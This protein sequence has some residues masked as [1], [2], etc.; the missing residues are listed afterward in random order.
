MT[1]TVIGAGVF[2]AWCAWFLSERHRVTL[3]DQYGP[4]NA[5]ASSADH[6]RV[7]RCGYGVDEIYSSWARQ[8]LEDWRALETRTGRELVVESGALF[9]G[10]SGNQYIG[11]THTTLDRLGVEVESLDRDTLARRFPQLGLT[12]LGAALFERRAGVIRARAAVHALVDSMIA[13]GRV[14]YRVARAVRPDESRRHEPVLPRSGNALDADVLIFA[15]GPWLASMFPVAVGGR[16]RSTRQEVLHFGVPAG[17]DRFSITQFP[18][19]ID[20]EAGFYGIPD[21]DASG[22]KIGIDRHG[23]VIDPDTYDRL[24]PSE[25]VASTRTWLGQRFPAL[26]DAPLLD[27]HVCQYENTSSGDFLIDRHPAWNHVWIV[28]GGSGHGFKHGPAVGRHVAALV[29]GEAAVTERFKLASKATSAVRAV[30]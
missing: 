1:I 7:I 16:I 19:W 11:D 13:E 29:D 21:F 22:F 18:V 12:A 28:G 27:A 24:V 23:P 9:L 6:S 3:I 2:G 26:A 5:R 30:Y 10:A 14:R 25:L 17:D 4:A 8:S 20:F 15:C